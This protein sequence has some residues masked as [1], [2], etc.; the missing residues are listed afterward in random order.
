M[1]ISGFPCIFLVFLC[2]LD[3]QLMYRNAGDVDG[4]YMYRSAN[5]QN[6]VTGNERVVQWK[7]KS[8]VELEKN[9]TC[10]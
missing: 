5:I 8:H 1:Y 4:P 10:P 7:D 2:A 3:L 9:D 6:L